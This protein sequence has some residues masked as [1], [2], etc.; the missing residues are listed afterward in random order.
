[1]G[2][3]SRSLRDGPT[4]PGSGLPEENAGFTCLG[5]LGSVNRRERRLAND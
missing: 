1:M 5:V 3:L 4:E 2:A